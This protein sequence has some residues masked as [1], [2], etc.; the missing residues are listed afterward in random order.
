MAGVMVGIIVGYPQ[1][2]DDPT[3]NGVDAIIS[4]IFLLEVV[5]KMIAE[6]GPFHRCIDCRLLS[7]PFLSLALPLPIHRFRPTP[8]F[9]L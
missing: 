9:S 6:G 5:V 8:L 4:W 3:A 1:M 7:R 2:T